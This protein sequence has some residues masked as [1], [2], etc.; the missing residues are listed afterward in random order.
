M[1]F[2]N[3]EGKFNDNS[4]LLDGFLFGAPNS[5]A[6]YVIENNGTRML[7]DTSTPD[8]VKRIINKLKE[9]DIYPIHK[10]LLSHAH[11]DHTAAVNEFKAL[12]NDVGI[13]VLASENAIDNLRK[14][15]A[16]NEPFE[17]TTEPIEEVT[18]LKEGDII[19]LNGLKLEVINFFGHTMDSIALLD[20][21]NRNI[22][23]GDAVGNK[24]GYT[25]I[26][27]A[28]MPPEFDESE[29]LKTFQKLR[30]MKDKLN[31]IALAHFGVWTEGDFE[32][33]LNEMEDFHFKSKN[34]IIRWYN[35]KLS[36]REI[37]LKYFETYIPNSK[38][39]EYGLLDGL[40]MNIKWLIEGL[41]RS[42]FI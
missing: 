20:A 30:D 8:Q 31:S 6:L 3:K 9:Y 5:L 39:I 41:K 1:V 14:P 12:V 34:S 23:T 22:F 4:F 13:E 37:S 29:L 15:A 42:G 27:P 7:I 33:F 11:W 18:L 32:I 17:A 38:I 19:D 2:I 10:I 40:E 36:S 26:Q 35:E 24:S 21:K 25:Y 16:I 28:F